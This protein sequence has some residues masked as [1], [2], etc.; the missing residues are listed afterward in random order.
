MRDSGSVAVRECCIMSLSHLEYIIMYS[1]FRI[2]IY[3]TIKKKNINKN[4]TMEMWRIV[5]Y[6]FLVRCGFGCSLSE[7]SRWWIS[8]CYCRC[9]AFQ[10]AICIKYSDVVLN[11]YRIAYCSWTTNEFK[12]KSLCFLIITTSNWWMKFEP[13]DIHASNKTTANTW[14]WAHENQ[15]HQ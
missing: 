8:I 15:T 5:L 3:S 7:N 10:W 2:V 4:N 9:S 13:G 14:Y 1:V 12:I 6:F 11:R